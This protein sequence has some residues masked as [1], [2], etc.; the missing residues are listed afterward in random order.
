VLAAIISTFPSIELIDV[1]PE[2]RL[3]LGR[4]LFSVSV[5]SVYLNTDNRPL[6]ARRKNKDK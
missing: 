3:A 6:L 5:S 4:P 2:L 1:L